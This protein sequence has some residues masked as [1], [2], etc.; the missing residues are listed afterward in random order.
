M[1]YLDKLLKSYAEHISLPWQG[2]RS[3]PERTIIARYDKEDERRLRLRGG[4]FQ[5]ATERVGHRWLLLDVTHAFAQWMAQQEYRE[6]YFETPQALEGYEVGLLSEF[7]EHLLRSLA[8]QVKA[9]AGPNH[10]VALL[11]A[12]AL[13]GVSRVSKLMEGLA[14]MVGGRLLVF[15]PGERHENNWRLLGARDGWNYLA[16]P[17][18]GNA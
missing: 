7:T 12:G 13:F 6:A 8:E 11:G 4:E 2:I 3:G 5:D 14:P 10:V 17:L 18:D 1:S 15:F 9:G 16:V